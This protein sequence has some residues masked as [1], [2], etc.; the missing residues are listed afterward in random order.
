MTDAGK[1]DDGVPENRWYSETARIAGDAHLLVVGLQPPFKW[2]RKSS[3]DGLRYCSFPSACA[4]S[5]SPVM[6]MIANTNVSIAVS[7]SFF[8]FG[9]IHYT[10]ET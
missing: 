1:R 6:T 7:I 5:A 3:T 10:P 2:S 4:L 9:R 8:L